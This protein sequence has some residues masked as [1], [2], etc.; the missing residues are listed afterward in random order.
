M[1]PDDMGKTHLFDAEEFAKSILTKGAVLVTVMHDRKGPCTVKT[2][3]LVDEFNAEEAHKWHDVSKIL[4]KKSL[5][6][7]QLIENPMRYF[8]T[9]T[10]E[11]SAA[12]YSAIKK[13]TVEAYYV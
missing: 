13:G 4:E 10:T 11:T 6:L 3:D 8:Y 1:P 7:E 9:V 2:F 5:Q 12:T